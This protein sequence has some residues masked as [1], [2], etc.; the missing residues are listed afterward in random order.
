MTVII[1]WHA[2]LIAAAGILVTLGLSRW[3]G[4]QRAMMRAGLAIGAVL[5]LTG[6]LA[7][8]LLPVAGGLVI[9]ALWSWHL[10]QDARGRS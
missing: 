9:A 8:F 2:A 3:L 4:G 10:L 5:I 7:G 1:H 6:L